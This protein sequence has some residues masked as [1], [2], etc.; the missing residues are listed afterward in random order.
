MNLIHVRNS[1]P[2]WNKLVFLSD[3]RGIPSTEAETAQDTAQ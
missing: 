1:D 2:L 3:H